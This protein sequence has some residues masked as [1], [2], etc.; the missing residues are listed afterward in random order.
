MLYQLSY[1]RLAGSEAILP[2]PARAS[3]DGA[4]ATYGPAA[5]APATS[6]TIAF[7]SS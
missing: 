2:Q 4:G 1:S 5:S 7:S 3:R 6:N